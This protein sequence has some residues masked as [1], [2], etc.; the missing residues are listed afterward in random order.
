M[1]ESWSKSVHGDLKNLGVNLKSHD[2]LQVAKVN[3][4]F[5]SKAQWWFGLAGGVLTGWTLQ[6]PGSGAR[7]FG[8][9][10]L[11]DTLPSLRLPGFLPIVGFL[12]DFLS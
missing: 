9:V 1:E 8:V 5:I 3:P 4:G 12:D 11:C 10:T 7:V 6:S 2:E